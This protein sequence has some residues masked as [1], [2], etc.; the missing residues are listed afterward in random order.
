MALDIA[1]RQVLIDYFG[2]ENGFRWHARILLAQGPDA[3]WVVATPDHNV[4][5]LDLSQHRVRVLRRGGQ[6]QNPNECY[7]F[8]PLQDGELDELV[9]QASEL[10]AVLGFA[11]GAVAAVEPA[12]RATWRIADPAL[13]TC[14]TPVPTAAVGDEDVMLIRGDAALLL[15]D[16]S[17][18]PV[19]RVPDD[20]LEAWKEAK[21][22]GAGRDPRLAARSRLAV[23]ASERTA[24]EA[25]AAK[26]W[27]P[28]PKKPEQYPLA[29]PLV[30]PEFFDG[31]RHVGHSLAFH[32]ADWRQR[33]GV[34][35][36]GVI[37]Q[38]HAAVCEL[39]RFAITVD[40]LDPSNLAV[41]EL[42]V[43]HVVRIEQAVARNAKMPDWEGLDEII[44]TR[45]APSGAVE[46]PAFASWLSG[47]QRDKAQVLKQGR[48][49]REERVAEGKRKGSGKGGDK[50]K[51]KGE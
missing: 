38:F 2:D 28:P 1:Q 7:L 5:F 6:V 15:V 36:R 49:L 14:G 21:W 26:A 42:T 50:D 37:A 29:G 46:V 45:L 19:Q 41:T 34:P 3:S 48:L 31:L 30:L 11:R 4:E 40:C 22:S 24:T 13:A 12:A 23:P 35:E 8:D 20:G 10:A 43:R 51:D 17:W 9:A 25:E 32:H 39:L 33:S 18:V 47:L 44:S 16:T 27:R